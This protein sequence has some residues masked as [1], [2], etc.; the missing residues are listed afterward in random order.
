M[1]ISLSIASILPT[2]TG[3]L[4]V[5]SN[6]LPNSVIPNIVKQTALAL[7]VW[8][9]SIISG[10]CTCF[11]LLTPRGK[12]SLSKYITLPLRLEA[13]HLRLIFYTKTQM[14]LVKHLG[15][16]FLYLP[17]KEI[18]FAM[19]PFRERRSKSWRTRIYEFCNISPVELEQV[20]LK[21][22]QRT[23]V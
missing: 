4:L 20:N 11:D 1:S 6:Q 13:M 15:F 3:S 12:L 17:H 2:G 16:S 8:S 9:V 7:S 22:K 23:Q 18:L 19:N 5:L 14:L 21:R 10:S